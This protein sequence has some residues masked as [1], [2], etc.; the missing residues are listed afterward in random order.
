GDYQFGFHDDVEPIYSTGKGLS[1]AVVR[2]LSAA[3]N[4]PEWM[5][6]FR[7]KSLETFNK[8]PMQTW[9]ADLSDINFDDII[10][11]QKA[12]DKPARSW[13]DV[14]EKIKETFDRIGI[15]E[16][17]RAYLAGA[18]AQY[19]SEVVYHNMKGEFEKLGIIFTDTDSALKEYPD[20]FK[21]YFAKL[22]PPTDN[23]L[24]ALNSAVWS[25]GTFIYVPKGVKV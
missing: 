19:E 5:L 22:V 9:G 4:E 8:M 15:P 6:E 2:E 25:G 20:L 17:E 16:A 11:Y 24:A 10:Y 3:K 21:Q 7:L 23:K 1:E 13:D 12:S 14:P 18:S